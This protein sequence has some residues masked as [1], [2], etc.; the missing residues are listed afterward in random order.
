MKPLSNRGEKLDY[1]PVNCFRVAWRLMARAAWAR[2][3]AKPES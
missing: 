2:E 1:S 3:S